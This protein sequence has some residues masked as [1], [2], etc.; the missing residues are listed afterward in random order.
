MF[1][2]GSSRKVVSSPTS[3][4]ELSDCCGSDSVEE[5]FFGREKCHRRWGVILSSDKLAC[6]ILEEV[7]T[8]CWPFYD[9]DIEVDCFYEDAE[10]S[11][12][13]QLG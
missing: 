9:G 8:R 1:G 3:T 13:I 11:F 5:V 6:K 12:E 10:V 4:R 7:L 2:E